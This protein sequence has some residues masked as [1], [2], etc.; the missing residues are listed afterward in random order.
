MKV[1]TKLVPDVAVRDIPPNKL[2]V[3]TSGGHE[4]QVVMRF[5]DTLFELNNGQGN[6]WVNLKNNTMTARPLT[7]YDELIWD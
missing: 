3:I 1:K 7:K 2:Y 5:S 4:G 6:W